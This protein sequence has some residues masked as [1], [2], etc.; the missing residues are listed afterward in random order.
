MEQRLKEMSESYVEKVFFD[1]I[2][3]QGNTAWI[4]THNING[5][6]LLNLDTYEIQF[7][8]MVP[9][10]WIFETG[11]YS[12]ILKS[13]KYLILVPLK[14][15]K[16]AI[17]DIEKE[18]FECYPKINEEDF[19]YSG[20]VF[21]GKVFLIGQ[22]RPYITVFNITT[23]DIYYIK[24]GKEWF[25]NRKV[26]KG[27]FFGRK[28]RT[29]VGKYYYY[30]IC[31]DN[32]VARLDMESESV[33][34]FEIKGC[35]NGMRMMCQ[36]GDDFW[37]TEWDRASVIKWNEN[38]GIIAKSKFKEVSSDIFRT[39]EMIYTDKLWLFPTV[40]DHVLI[41]DDKID[42]WSKVE[43]FDKY[44]I[45]TCERC[46]P[47]RQ[48]F[49][50]AIKQDNYLYVFSGYTC[51]FIRYNLVNSN[52]MARKIVLNIEEVID[53]YKKKYNKIKFLI[54]N[55]SCFLKEFIRTL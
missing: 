46:H 24:S 27:R 28:D 13:G 12:C 45:N 55:D 41:Y 47:W 19:F 40:G 3:I 51:D 35:S 38:E 48:T 16:I 54:E 18:K 32:A 22:N 20:C 33:T 52:I 34:Y 50:V 17:Y 43:A 1:A 10:V 14:A 53:M 44:G 42:K 49:P 25:R 15:K 9:D 5:L 26:I 36:E 23:N 6:Y 7:K 4:Y 8:G 29:V 30:A 11:L 39:G 2:Y 37:I 31:N 21:D